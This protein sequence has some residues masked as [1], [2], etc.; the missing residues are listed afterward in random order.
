MRDLRQGR[1]CAV[2]YLAFMV[3]L[4][5]ELV[6]RDVLPIVN[7]EIVARHGSDSGSPSKPR[8]KGSTDREFPLTAE[9][10]GL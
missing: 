7:V 3:E 1:Y 8:V 9:A 10:N 4:K 6:A 5:A 2:G